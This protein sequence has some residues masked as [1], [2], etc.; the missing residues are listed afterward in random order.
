LAGTIFAGALMDAI[1][2]H[3]S[4]KLKEGLVLGKRKYNG[5]A[6]RVIVCCRVEQQALC[7]VRRSTILLVFGEGGGCSESRISKDR[8]KR[9]EERHRRGR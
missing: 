4:D 8:M 6:M 5:G 2:E 3:W 9:T 7:N 1:I